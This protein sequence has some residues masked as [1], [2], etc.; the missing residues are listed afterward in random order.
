[1]CKHRKNISYFEMRAAAQFARK[2]GE[3]GP[4]SGPSYDD[5][6]VQFVSAIVMAASSLEAFINDVF[7]Y[8]HMSILLQDAVIK[9]LWP[10]IEKEGIL[11]KYLLAVKLSEQQA[12][13]KGTAGYQNADTLIA[14]RNALVHFKPEWD[15]EKNI[16]KKIELRINRKFPLSRIAHGDCVFPDQCMSY[17]CARWCVASALTSVDAFCTRTG[18][19]NRYLIGGAHLD[20]SVP[21]AQS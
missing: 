6:T 5:I 17:G 3:I 7:L 4:E 8:V 19:E 18:I 1:M 16:H 10:L 15:D 12:L 13:G 9:A 2:A 11:E 14:M 20:V 21:P